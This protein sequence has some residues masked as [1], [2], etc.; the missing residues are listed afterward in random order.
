MEYF[1]KVFNQGYVSVYFLV[2]GLVG[3]VNVSDA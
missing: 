1:L 3:V 2:I